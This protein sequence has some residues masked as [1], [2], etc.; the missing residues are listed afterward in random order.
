MPNTSLLT[1][2]SPKFG[3]LL[4]FV[5][6]AAILLA[7]LSPSPLTAQGLPFGFSPYR[8]HNVTIGGGGGFIPG[9]VFSTTETRPPGTRW[10]AAIPPEA[11][12]L[13]IAPNAKIESRFFH[14][15]R[16]PPTQDRSRGACARSS[17][18]TICIEL[19]ASSSNGRSGDAAANTSTHEF[20]PSPVRRKVRDRVPG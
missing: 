7:A 4:Q 11:S 10:T 3:G 15:A 16:L 6:V 18:G 1:S 9:I 20:S 13:P 12:M 5:G 2:S 14:S 19:A 17:R 8:F